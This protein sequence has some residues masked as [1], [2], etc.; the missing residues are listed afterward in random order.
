MA[1]DLDRVRLLIADTGSDPLLSDAQLDVFLDAADNDTLLAAAEAL[2]VI[3]AS[4]V[5][6][7]KKIRT[8]DLATDGPAVA[9]SLLALADRYR[10]RAVDASG[11]DDWFDVVDTAGSCRPV[12]PERA[13]REVWG[14]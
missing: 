8:Q 3:A 11:A 6:V 13:E 12:W 9:A 2:E 4:E 14:L 1:S 5:L 10:S 7:S